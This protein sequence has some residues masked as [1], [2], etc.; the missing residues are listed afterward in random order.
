MP[1]PNVS[2]LYQRI[3][4]G[5]EGGNEFARIVNLLLT[6]ENKECHDEFV[7]FSDAQ[8]DYKGVDSY[9]QVTKGRAIGFQY[10]F[11][12]SP[13]KKE[14]KY[15]IKKS[16]K[17]A[18]DSFEILEKWIIITPEDLLKNDMIWLNALKK[19]YSFNHD[20][21]SMADYA[22]KNGFFPKRT[23]FS[24]EHW[25]HTKLIEL[26]I[27]HPHLGEHYYPELLFEKSQSTVELLKIGIDSSNCNWA[28]YKEYENHF[29]QYP[30]Y[31][32][33]DKSK[34][35]DVIFDFFFVNN[36]SIIH[37]LYSIEIKVIDVWNDIKGIPSD[38]FLKSIGIIEIEIDF[39]KEITRHE[40][41]DPIIFEKNKPIRFKVQLKDINENIPENC[42][43]LK[44]YF[45]FHKYKLE[46]EEIYL[47][48]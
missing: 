4:N 36:S 30:I 42:C 16:L 7:V 10:K 39:E 40:L 23:N 13:L 27:K 12:S 48:F 17:N 46:T 26:F 28:R 5:S 32:E 21:K 18:L 19:N 11:Y 8:G 37:L 34:T 2:S 24:I 33:E 43:L 22:E 9:I 25:G 6:A 35:S 41:S 3:N 14:H 1:I 47:S 29:S 45:D 44:I 38:K 31:K 20:F 15:Q